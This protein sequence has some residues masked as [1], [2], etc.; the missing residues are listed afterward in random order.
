MRVSMQVIAALFAAGEVKSSFIGDIENYFTQTY[1]SFLDNAMD[2]YMELTT[3]R[4]GNREL[5][6]YQSEDEGV[7]QKLISLDTNPSHYAMDY[8]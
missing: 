1:E 3:N 8:K 7:S 2:E 6:L 5:V 4:F